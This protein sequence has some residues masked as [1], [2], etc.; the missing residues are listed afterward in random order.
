MFVTEADFGRTDDVPMGGQVGLDRARLHDRTLGQPQRLPTLKVRGFFP[1]P[2]ARHLWRHTY[3]CKGLFMQ[4][5]FIRETPAII[6]LKTQ[7]SF[8]L[9]KVCLP[10]DY[11]LYFK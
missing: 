1:L 6:A 8:C 5:F 7:A 11:F 10:N 3:M 4:A 2:A 9:K